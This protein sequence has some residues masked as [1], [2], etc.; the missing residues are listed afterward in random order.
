M[1]RGARIVDGTGAPW[2]LGDVAVTGETIA[3]VRTLPS[4][5]AALTLDVSGLTLA[6]GFVDTHSHS[7]GAVFEVPAAENL[8]R[9]GVTTAIEGPDGSSP[10]PLAPFLAKLGRTP[11]GINF[12]SMVGHGSIRASVMGS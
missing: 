5:T 7:R 8:V 2:F 1:L 9:Q 12:G 6:P 10:V 11:L 4:H 3:A